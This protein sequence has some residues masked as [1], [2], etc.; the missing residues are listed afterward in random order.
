M[1]ENKE[2]LALL[3]NIEKSNRQQVKLTR[4]ICVFALVAAICCG[5]TLW[6]V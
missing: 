6:L 3:Q 2:L 5:W 1:E 4:L